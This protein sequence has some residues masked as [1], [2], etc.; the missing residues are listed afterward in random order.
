M[1]KKLTEVIFLILEPFDSIQSQFYMY[2]PKVFVNR[3]PLYSVYSLSEFCLIGPLLFLIIKT[4]TSNETL[5]VP[6]GV[7]FH[8]IM[9]LCGHL[10]EY[11]VLLLLYLI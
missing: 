3:V 1:K 7:K 5:S 10:L 2:D 9:Y 4:V 8:D 6:Q 11:S